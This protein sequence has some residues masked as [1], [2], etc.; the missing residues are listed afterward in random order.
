M[1]HS[2]LAWSQTTHL[3]TD[4]SEV[5]L[6]NGIPRSVW[7]GQTFSPHMLGERSLQVGTPLAPALAGEHQRHM[8]P[9]KEVVV[10]EDVHSRD[11]QVVA[12][13]GWLIGDLVGDLALYILRNHIQPEAPFTHPGMP[14]LLLRLGVRRLRPLHSLHLRFPPI[15]KQGRPPRGRLA[16]RLTACLDRFSSRLHSFDLHSIH[17]FESS[18]SFLHMGLVCLLGLRLSSPQVSLVSP[19]SLHGLRQVSRDCRLAGAK[20]MGRDLSVLRVSLTQLRQHPGP[21]CAEFLDVLLGNRVSD[22]F[23]DLLTHDVF[24]LLQLPA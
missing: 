22:S 20:A 5:H 6:Q 4:L 3:V 18:L 17:S 8:V 1:D 9:A 23:G 15:I 21:V 13:Q 12:H 10:V 11:I 2:P 7:Y 14:K 16:E 24:S 19:I